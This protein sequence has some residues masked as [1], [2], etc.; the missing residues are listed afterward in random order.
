MSWCQDLLPNQVLS[1]THSSI[2]LACC[3]FG[4][5]G[6]ALSRFSK[7]VEY[8]GALCSVLQVDL[9]ILTGN[10]YDSRGVGKLTM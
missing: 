10:S 4:R 2:A 7:V 3:R 6:R 8:M 5:T 9:L 1:T